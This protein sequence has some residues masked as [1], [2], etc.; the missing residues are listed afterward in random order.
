[1]SKP[2][3]I[4]VHGAWHSPAHYQEFLDVLEEQG[5]PCVAPSLPSGDVVP[6]ENPPEAD[7]SC[8]REIAQNLVDQG[9]EIIAFGHSYGGTVVTNAFTGLGIRTRAAEGKSGG[10]RWLV[11][12][13]AF[14]LVQ[15]ESLDGAAPPEATPWQRHEGTLK[16][17]TEGHDIG[18]LLYSDLPRKEHQRWLKL[19]R[20]F[21]IAS[22]QYP[23]QSPAYRDIETLY[24]YC[25]NDALLPSVVQRSLVTKVRERGFEVHEESL[26]AGHFP[27]LSMPKE[28]ANIISNLT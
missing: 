26:Q 17:F 21:P 9:K 20:P 14:I 6:P 15:N 7:A 22:S 19:L 27:S 1:M 8:I 25:E 5:Y 12:C 13:T 3:V 4:L 2:T 16:V 11:Y 24:I 10:V 18:A 28:L 23:T